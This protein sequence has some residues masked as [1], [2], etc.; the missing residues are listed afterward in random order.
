MD[1]ATPDSESA[2]F[3]A[4]IAAH[5]TSSAADR[6][7]GLGAN[8]QPVDPEALVLLLRCVIGLAVSD[9]PS[10]P[11]LVRRCLEEVLPKRLG[12]WLLSPGVWS[13]ACELGWVA[14]Q[15]SLVALVTR[16]LP[17]RAEQVA[18]LL[19]DW[20]HSL[21]EDR[22]QVEDRV[23]QQQQQ[24][25]QQAGPR[26]A[27]RAEQAP[28]AEQQ[29]QQ[30]QQQP[31]ANS[32]CRYVVLLPEELPHAT[33]CMATMWEAAAGAVGQALTNTSLQPHQTAAS[34]SQPSLTTA[35]VQLLEA[36]AVLR[37]PC[38]LATAQQLLRS[39]VSHAGQPVVGSALQV[40]H[41]YGWEA[42]R[43]AAER[44][45]ADCTGAGVTALPHALSLLRRLIDAEAGSRVPGSK[46]QGGKENCSPQPQTGPNK[47]QQ[48]QQQQQQQQPQQQQQNSA[49]A[50]VHLVA[51]TGTLLNEVAATA[52]S[53]QVLPRGGY[54]A[55]CVVD[56]F[57]A[58]QALMQA[59]TAAA[60]CGTDPST[61]AAA[62]WLGSCLDRFAAAIASEDAEQRFPP[63]A[64]LA[65]ACQQL[66]Q[67]WG[68]AA[69]A[70]G[71]RCLLGWH[72]EAQL[73]G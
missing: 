19:L 15:P 57:A 11:A 70:C 14:L 41:A 63:D 65:R 73:A 10:A 49:A 38:L 43:P 61:C 60:A 17:Q 9:E 34:A 68:S 50:F 5:L 20:A 26:G 27:Q 58:V 56:A 45:V 4:A 48:Q 6:S 37:L 2:A 47:P 8:A 31:E 36:A 72:Q 28:Q 40:H 30:E 62:H 42:V 52:G 12:G 71:R 53:S 69:A 22:R 59:A 21:A 35:A 39:A 44:L 1:G 51:L 46:V 67:D 23:E 18:G 7:V 33:A 25:A 54:A 24:G 66:H 55:A 16:S 3:A 29:E 64:C 32:A 13:A